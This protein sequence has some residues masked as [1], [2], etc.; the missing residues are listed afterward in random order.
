MVE[1][2]VF[3]VEPVPTRHRKDFLCLAQLWRV[4]QPEKIGYCNE[5][6]YNKEK[7]GA[8]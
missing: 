7:G 8:K 3:E 2:E 1:L 4:L 6:R 5:Y